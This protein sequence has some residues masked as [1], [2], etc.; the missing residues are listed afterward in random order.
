M[1][2]VRVY[3]EDNLIIREFTDLTNQQVSDLL[4]LAIIV[5]NGEVKILDNGYRL[6]F[7]DTFQEIIVS[8]D[9]QL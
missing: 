6:Y 3:T 5:H 2:T 8:N 9:T 4:E 7:N 1:K